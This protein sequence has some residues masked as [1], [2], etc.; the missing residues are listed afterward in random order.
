[1]KDTSRMFW[2]LQ[3]IATSLL[4]EDLSHVGDV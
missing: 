4:K 1:M 2:S 3:Q